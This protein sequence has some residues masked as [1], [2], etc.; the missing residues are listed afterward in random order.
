MR[1]QRDGGEGVLPVPREPAEQVESAQRAEL[2]R[3]ADRVPQ[4]AAERDA[5]PV[6]QTA[7]DRDADR[8]PQTAADR[9]AARRRLDRLADRWW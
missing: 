4:R 9:V 2:D 1:R 8:V 6:P 5:D 7:A 3:D